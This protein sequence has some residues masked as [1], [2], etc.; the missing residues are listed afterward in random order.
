MR[1]V[2]SVDFKERQILFKG[3]GMRDNE[4]PYYAHLARVNFDGTG[5]QILTE[6]DGTHTWKFSPDKRYFTDTWSRVDM[7]PKSVLRDCQTGKQVTE[8]EA[9]NLS[10]LSAVGW[11]PAERFEAVG[12][13]GT[14]K[15]YGII[16]KPSNFDPSKV[17]AVVEQI[18]AGPQ[19]YFCPKAFSTLGRQH[20]L[21]EL[22]FVLV[23]IDGMGTNWRSKAFH[24]TAFKNLKDA[25]FPDR[26]LWMQAAAKTRPWMDISR[27]G[28]Y[29]G[30][31]G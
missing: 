24:D 13:D 9:G 30:S 18:Y 28:I 15:I 17:Y 29:G 8:L 19:D 2:E 16:I 7:A 3:L 6:G 25:G 10:S 20:E 22:G 5:L 27:V 1:S 11:L 23:Q 14:T 21:A 31:A 12:R 26:K 4:D